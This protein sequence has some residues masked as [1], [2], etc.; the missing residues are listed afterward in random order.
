M[1]SATRSKLQ[2]DYKLSNAYICN[3]VFILVKNLKQQI[4]PETLFLT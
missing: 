2:I 4:I 1:A 3:N